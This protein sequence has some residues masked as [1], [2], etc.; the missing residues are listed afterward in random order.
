MDQYKNRIKPENLPKHIAIIMDGNGRWAKRQ[1][2]PRVF[3]HKNG[4][5]TVRRIVEA[6]G[7]IGI[8][9]LTLYTFSKENWNRS[10][11]EVN[12]LMQ[13]LVSSLNKELK[14]LMKNNVRL[15]SIG[16]LDNLPEKVFSKLNQAIEMT[17]NNTGLTLILALSYGARWEIVRAV[18]NIA[19]KVQKGEIP[20]EDINDKLISDN[21]LTAGIPDPELIIRTS[22]EYRISNFLLFQAAYSEFIFHDKFWPEFQKED[23]YES[24]YKFQNRERRFGKTSEQLNEQTEHASN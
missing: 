10:D 2:K 22:G 18:Q 21:L 6:A 4:V 15:L 16:D 12:A 9:Y 11:T 19:A 7:E 23:F 13:I 14:T 8:S 3:G 20:L 24:I 1:K 17:K 5:N